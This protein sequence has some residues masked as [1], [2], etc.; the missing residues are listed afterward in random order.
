[1]LGERAA[2]RNSLAGEPVVS[3]KPHVTSRVQIRRPETL[4]TNHRPGEAPAHP[5]EPAV[6]ANMGALFRF[7]FG[8]VRVHDQS[9][10]DE[11]GA[12]AVT[13]GEHVHVAPGAYDAGSEDGKHVLAH[14]LT[15]V[16][17]QSSSRPI[18]GNTAVLEQEAETA[19]RESVAG[20]PP[21]VEHAARPGGPQFTR[22]TFHGRTYEVGD[23][24]LNAQALRDIRR[25]GNLL[26]GAD[27]AHGQLTLHPAPPGGQLAHRS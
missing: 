23:V 26:A 21:R 2:G 9:E 7:D 16:V 10:L 1:M 12:A 13:H 5:I 19:A 27:Q 18:S 17:Q 8:R 11:H 24:V 15:H 22:V 20:R 14:E 3:E 25:F 6:R 4:A